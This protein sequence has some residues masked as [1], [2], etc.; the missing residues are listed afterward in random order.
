MH[1]DIA[2]IPIYI[3]LHFVS[4]KIPVFALLLASI[5]PLCGHAQAK[6]LTVKKIDVPGLPEASAVPALLDKAGIESHDVD[7]ANWESHPYVPC[8][9]FRIAH[10]GNAILLHFQVTENDVRGVTEEDNG[11]V[12]EDA[13]AEFFVAPDSS[14]CYYNFEC[15]CTGKLLLQGGKPGDRPLASADVLRLVRR[16]SSL[17][18]KP[19]GEIAGETSWQLALVIP[20]EAFFRSAIPSLDGRVMRGNF[21]K[22]GNEQ[23][24]P[25]FV[26]WSP[27][28]LPRPQFH[29]PE[30]FGTLRCE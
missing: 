18:S 12:W 10:T 14:E 28:G 19:V 26:S 6:E 21:Y 5:I 24:T 22:C 11:P 29:C 17:G 13:C 15:N 1:M 30:F 16:W 8:T 9:R 25:N 2:S 7:V 3:M 27:I 4:Y 20:V 23:K